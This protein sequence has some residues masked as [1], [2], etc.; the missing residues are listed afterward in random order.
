[1]N[2]KNNPMRISIHLKIMVLSICFGMNSSE[3]RVSLVFDRCGTYNAYGV[4]HCT[5]KHAILT[6]N[7][8]TVSEMQF[9]I[10]RSDVA[11]DYYSNQTLRMELNVLSL[12]PKPSILIRDQKLHIVKPEAMA[13]PPTLKSESPCK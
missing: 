12:N 8:G 7:P 6:T 9:K 11:C 2:Q 10:K 1:M 3:A 5:P 13:T 4:I